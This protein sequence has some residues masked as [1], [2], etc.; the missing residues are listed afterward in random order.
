MSSSIPA[1]GVERVIS[2][3]RALAE[4][5]LWLAFVTGWIWLL[6]ALDV[7]RGIFDPGTSVAHNLAFLAS[8]LAIVLILNGAAGLLL[9]GQS[10]WASRGVAVA[11]GLGIGVSG[12]VISQI[13]EVDPDLRHYLAWGAYACGAFL[14]VVALTR[15]RVIQ[16]HG[17]PEPLGPLALGVLVILALAA[18]FLIYLASVAF[19]K[20]MVGVTGDNAW[21]DLV[22][23][24]ILLTGALS[25]M[26]ALYRRNWGAAALVVAGAAALA[27]AT[28]KLPF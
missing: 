26:T 6:V 10:G 5:F 1:L 23:V 21:P 28:Q 24:S 7:K 17:D 4:P 3:P 27:L 19:K 11:A 9:Q 13:K 14:V 2:Y 18:M 8:A 22:P 25:G 12:W 16:E 15:W 20:G